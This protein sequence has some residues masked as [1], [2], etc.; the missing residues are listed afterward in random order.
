M[1]Y[2]RIPLFLSEPY[3]CL[4]HAIQLSPNQLLGK[5]KAA[6]VNDEAEVDWSDE[7]AHSLHSKALGKGDC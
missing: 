4:A 5:M 7:R 1:S 6:P 3:P 2:V